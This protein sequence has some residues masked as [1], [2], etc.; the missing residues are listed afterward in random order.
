MQQK[1][2]NEVTTAKKYAEYRRAKEQALKKKHG[3]PQ[4]PQ[5]LKNPLTWAALTAIVAVAAFAMVYMV[6]RSRVVQPDSG[7]PGYY[8]MAQTVMGGGAD[9]AR[10]SGVS[11]AQEGEDT[12][13]RL[14]FEG[15]LP[16]YSVSALGEP[17]R[18]IISM[19]N[20][21][22]WEHSIGFDGREP[23]LLLG[24]F[25]NQA[26]AEGVTELY[27]QTTRQIGYRLSEEG[28]ELVLRLHA[29]AE[30][31][32]AGYYVTV[33]AYEA[34]CAGLFD[35]AD[36]SPVL[37]ADGA[38][39]ALIS[40]RY[41]T[42]VEA[43]SFAQTLDARLSV[44]LPGV[45]S[46]VV[47]LSGNEAPPLSDAAERAA[48]GAA[49]VYR[50]YA[51][52]A[53]PWLWTSNAR[54][55]EWMPDMKRAL[56]TRQTASA[57]GDKDDYCELW[58]YD[59]TG[60]G[61]RLLDLE[62]RTVTEA[63]FSP[64]GDAL[65]FM[66]MTDAE[67]LLY[68]YSIADGRFAALGDVIGGNTYGFDFGG[69]AEL[70]LVGGIYEPRL[71]LW[72]SGAPTDAAVRVLEDMEGPQGS[73]A[74]GSPEWTPD[75][76]FMSDESESIYAFD[77]STGE[78]RYLTAGSDFKMSPDGR[79]MVITKFDSSMNVDTYTGL[80]LRDMSDGREVTIHS[81]EAIGDVCWSSG[82]AYVYFLTYN[83]DPATSA[84]FPSILNAY[85]VAAGQQKALGLIGSLDIGM[86]AND[87]EI[88]F[89]TIYE[90]AAGRYQSATYRLNI[91]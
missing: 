24:I 74:F 88:S 40:R 23:S 9:G 84:A 65:A 20:L 30:A 70:Y 15:G 81:G 34:Y 87:S 28:Q 29:I 85:D 22:G 49:E 4:P 55:V 67:S 45:L 76:I 12:V 60:K 36:L 17:A 43:E 82:G 53:Q 21:S 75:T 37:C 72:D 35:A 14:S 42:R 16:P 89:V 69:N 38:S 63:R 48:L 83:E 5:W 73:I 50:P 59:Q 57:S 86:G 66:E 7:V 6:N 19:R 26:S 2:P 58:L 33:G 13:I 44:N 79:Y 47:Q 32:E 31:A 90:S 3:P 41:D 51:G 64:A 78:R 54:L 77:I 52:S 18:V 1:K 46:S 91:G 56:F 39:V 61:Q 25:R 68:Y 71:T 62:F 11:T 10:L 8:S 27:L 80:K